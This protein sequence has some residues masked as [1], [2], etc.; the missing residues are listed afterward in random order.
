MH[1]LTNSSPYISSIHDLLYATRNVESNIN[2]RYNMLR[3][4][5][6]HNDFEKSVVKFLALFTNSNTG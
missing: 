6:E 5:Y 3:F 4:V 2:R 1:R